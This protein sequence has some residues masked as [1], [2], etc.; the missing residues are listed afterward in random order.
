[1]GFRSF[2][3]FVF[4]FVFR[5][6]QAQNSIE[7]TPLTGLSVFSPGHV[8]LTGKTYGAEIGYNF[9]MKESQADW[10]KRLYVNG[11]GITAGYRSMNQV[12]I[13]DSAESQGFLGSVYT[14][15]AKLN[16]RL[17]RLNNTTILL[18]PGAGIAYSTSS[19]FADG[20][21]IVASKINL[22]PQAR[23]EIRTPVS[24]SA[25]LIAGVGVFHY[26]NIALRV[27]NNGVNSFE[28][29]LGLVKNL[30]ASGK[31]RRDSRS[32]EYLKSFLEFSADIGRRG[33]YKS[34]AGNWKSGFNIGYNYKLNPTFSVRAGA[35]AVYYYSVY[36]GTK[37]SDQYFATAFSP[38]RYGLSAGGD[39]W[40]GKLAVTANYGYY[41]RFDSQYDIKTYWNAGLKYYI[42]SW[43]GVQGRGYVHKVQADYLGLGLV[44]RV[45]LNKAGISQVK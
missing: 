43:L 41:L 28:L 1:M 25:S 21:P 40:L 24:P 4:L 6:V 20:N 15:S 37:E 22:A 29:S 8:I 33:A 7:F 12:A 17:L 42:N 34:Y 14:L 38:W 26:S 3:V 13:K 44:F 36:D 11:V 30:K 27:P 16:I 5:S 10:V 31:P 32:A 19:Y 39:V 18:T 2:F 45:G 35:D 9:S 23:L